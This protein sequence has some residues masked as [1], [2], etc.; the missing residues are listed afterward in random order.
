M[1]DTV[2]SYFNKD[3]DPT[4]SHFR[5]IFRGQPMAVLFSTQTDAYVHLMELQGLPPHAIFDYWRD[6]R[7]DS[8]RVMYLVIDAR[9]GWRLSCLPGLGSHSGYTREKYHEKQTSSL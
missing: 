3:V 9:G 8:T 2:V 7:A 4:R 6:N 1:T 5:P